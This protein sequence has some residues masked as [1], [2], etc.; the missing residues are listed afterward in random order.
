MLGN[1]QPYIGR[2]CGTRKSVNAKLSGSTPRWSEHVGELEMHMEGT[3]AK[4][5]SRRRYLELRHGAYTSCLNF[6]IYEAASTHT[7]SCREAIAITMAQ[8]KSNGIELKHFC[9]GFPQTSH[10]VSEQSVQ[11]QRCK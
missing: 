9:E 3:V 6:V 11:R 2:T 1:G 7:V 4:E 5:R 10:P 8:P